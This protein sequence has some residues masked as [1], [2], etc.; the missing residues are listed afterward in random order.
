MDLTMKKKYLWYPVSAYLLS[1]NR[2]AI[3][4]DI[5]INCQMMMIRITVQIQ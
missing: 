5:W 2:M 1:L 3:L 4:K